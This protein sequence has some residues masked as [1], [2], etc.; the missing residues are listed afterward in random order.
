[1]QRVAYD[2]DDTL[3]EWFIN[4]V[5]GLEHGFTIRQRPSSEQ[6]RSSREQSALILSLAV[7]GGLRPEVQADGCGV[8]F[9]DQ[10]G[11]AALTY[12]NLAVVDVTGRKLPARFEPLPGGSQ[13]CCG[14]RLMVDQ[15]EAH[16]PITIDPIVQQEYLKAS[17]ID[18]GDQF[19]SSVAISGDT[20]VVGAL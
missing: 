18:Q 4:D 2:W 6:P 13:D 9:V 14:L 15:S 3:E 12:N 10:H 16:Y 1:G 20:V 19:G 8:R 7:R 5:R 11:A 17:N